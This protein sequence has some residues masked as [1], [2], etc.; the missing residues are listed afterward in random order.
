MR[1]RIASVARRH[2][3]DLV[4]LF[5]SR[6]RGTARVESDV[7]LAI[8]HSDGPVAASVFWELVAD[9]GEALA[10]LEVDVVDLGRADP[11]LQHQIFEAFEP[12]VDSPGALMAARLSSFHRY[13]DY[14]PF[15]EIERIAVR[16]ALGFDAH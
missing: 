9:F 12:L 8:R 13:I 2:G 5:G 3:L 16:R 4:L 6:A 10:P 11:L 7:D 14:R 1:S 15:L